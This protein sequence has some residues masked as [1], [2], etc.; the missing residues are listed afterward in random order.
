MPNVKT[1]VKLRIPGDSDPLEAGILLSRGSLDFCVLLL[2][3]RS[4]EA[5]DL[6]GESS[7]KFP[8][9]LLGEK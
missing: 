8:D 4:L 7:L 6:L 1:N 3:G 2:G 5:G 9:L